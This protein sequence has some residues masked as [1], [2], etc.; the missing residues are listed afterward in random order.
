M[1]ESIL[2]LV[3]LA[4]LAILCL[5]FSGFQ[6]LVL[7]V[8]GLALR[9]ALLALLAGA[10]VLCLRP[11]LLPIAEAENV[12]SLFPRMRQV[13][14]EPGTPLFGAAAAALI[15][16]VLLPL[17]AVIDVS[18]KLAGWRLRRLKV[19]TRE[20]RTETA[21]VPAPAAQRRVDRRAAAN[22]LAEAGSRK[23]YRVAD[24]LS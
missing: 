12:L 17:L 1:F 21:P 6:K 7:E 10:A 20:V 16:V 8:Y 22:T 9:L 13:L 3:G 15:T 23:P 24:H 4:L 18:R 19:L 11:E 2:A 5:P 14:P